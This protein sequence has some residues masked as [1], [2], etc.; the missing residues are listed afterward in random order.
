MRAQVACKHGNIARR[1]AVVGERALHI[2][3]GRVDADACGD[4]AH[5][6]AAKR[7]GAPRS[8]SASRQ[9]GRRINGERLKLAFLKK[10]AAGVPL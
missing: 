1:E 9:A 6:P 4:A 10:C 7:I 2:D 8:T 5:E 3:G